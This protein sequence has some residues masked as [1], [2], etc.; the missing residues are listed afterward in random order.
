M[1][2]PFRLVKGGRGAAPHVAADDYAL[3]PGQRSAL[4]ALSVLIADA[5][6]IALAGGPGMG[7][8]TVLRAAARGF[9]AGLVTIDDMLE[10]IR[11]HSERYWDIPLFEYLQQ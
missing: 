8:S 5:S 7:K 3:T 10:V 1:S 2:A 9:A 4:D 11:P 6:V